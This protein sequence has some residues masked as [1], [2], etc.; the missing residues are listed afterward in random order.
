VTKIEKRK[1]IFLII[2]QLLITYQ[3]PSSLKPENVT[4]G[5]KKSD[6]YF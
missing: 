1:Q 6:N 5:A 4:A 3:I 2:F